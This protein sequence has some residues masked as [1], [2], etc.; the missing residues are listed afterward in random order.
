MTNA[1]LGNTC[2]DRP[3]REDESDSLRRWAKINTAI[4]DIVESARSAYPSKTLRARIQ[5]LLRQVLGLRRAPLATPQ[6]SSAVEQCHR[7]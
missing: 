3:V 2:S 1:K 6:A 4:A 5:R 7:Q